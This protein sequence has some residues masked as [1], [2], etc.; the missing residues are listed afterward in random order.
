MRKIKYRS[1]KLFFAI[2]LSALYWVDIDIN[3]MYLV[4]RQSVENQ[5][6]T[7]SGFYLILFFWEKMRN[8]KLLKT[9]LFGSGEFSALLG[10]RI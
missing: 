2:M 3:S 1:Y 10:L 8:R 9:C 7:I 5:I 4:T 6:F